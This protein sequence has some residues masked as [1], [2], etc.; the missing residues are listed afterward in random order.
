[1]QSVFVGTR[2][3]G[4]SGMSGMCIWRCDRL[5]LGFTSLHSPGCQKSYLHTVACHH[6]FQT[7]VWASFIPESCALIGISMGRAHRSIARQEKRVSVA[8]GSLGLWQ[9]AEREVEGY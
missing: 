4:V 9:D 7:R 8:V 1:M 2:M 3:A 5:W 6:V